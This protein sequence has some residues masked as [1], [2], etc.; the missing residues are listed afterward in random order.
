MP[1]MHG[2]DNSNTNS[3][4]IGKQEQRR[5]QIRPRIPA[6]QTIDL[7]ALLGNIVF[8]LGLNP[9]YYY[10]WY[11]SSIQTHLC[12]ATVLVMIKEA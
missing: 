8:P 3:G 2:L 11:Y 4:G 7:D 5:I 12:T 10:L 6:V 1:T 9:F